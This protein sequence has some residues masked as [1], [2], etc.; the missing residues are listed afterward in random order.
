M[1]V[2]LLSVML[3]LSCHANPDI[4]GS[5][6]PTVGSPTNIPNCAQV[7]DRLKALC[8]YAPIDC[9]AADAG[10]FCDTQFTDPTELLC[11][12]YGTQ[13]DAGTYDLTQSCESAW[14]CVANAPTN[15]YG[16][17]DSAPPDDDAGDA[18]DTTDGAVE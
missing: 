1:S 7:C 6:V 8:G 5:K 17:G 3:M 12:G 9:T 10:G 2:S 4:D 18:G 13:N 11:I 16:G 14:D 15:G